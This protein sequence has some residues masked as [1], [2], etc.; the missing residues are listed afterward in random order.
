MLLIYRHLSFSL[1]LHFW[2]ESTT[3][4]PLVYHPVHSN[5]QSSPIFSPS[6]SFCFAKQSG[7]IANN[8]AGFPTG[9]TPVEGPKRPNNGLI[10]PVQ[11][12]YSRYRR[13]YTIR[14]KEKIRVNDS[15]HLQDERTGATDVVYKLAAIK[16]YKHQDGSGVL[17][18]KER[19]HRATGLQTM[20]Y[21]LAALDHRHHTSSKCFF[22]FYFLPF[23]SEKKE[24][25]VKLLSRR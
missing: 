4:P 9:W 19:K 1:S 20:D 11:C 13:I 7:N 10:W 14:I 23:L 2:T 16:S 5:C 22:F 15:Q 6:E 18:A 3:T 21:T 8:R 24:K 17:L 12:W 25:E